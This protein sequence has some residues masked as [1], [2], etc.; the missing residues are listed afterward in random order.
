MAAAPA[1]ITAHA[2]LNPGTIGAQEAMSLDEACKGQKPCMKCCKEN[3]NVIVVSHAAP[4]N[5]ESVRI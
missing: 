5:A 2:G 3:P 1:D 4:S